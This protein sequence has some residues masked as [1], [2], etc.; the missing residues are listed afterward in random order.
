[1]SS[2]EYRPMWAPPNAADCSQRF[3][4]IYC[5]QWCYIVYPPPPPIDL[6]DSSSTFSPLVIAVIGILASAFLLVS[7][8]T[9]VSKWCR[10]RDRSTGRSQRDP[11]ESFDETHHPSL[12]EPWHPLNSGLD[13]S[14][15]R[16]IAVCKYKKGDG[17]IE[18]TDCS[19]C[20]SEFQEGE[21]LRL[22]PKCSHAFH[23]SC[24]DI[25]L[26]AHSNCPLC[27]ASVAYNA[28]PIS[29]PLPPAEIAVAVPEESV[30]E[31]TN[32]PEN[33]PCVEIPAVEDGGSS[34]TD[35]GN[36][37]I[38]GRSDQDGE[39]LMSTVPQIL[40]RALSDLGGEDVLIEIDEEEAQALRRSFSMDS[41]SM[42]CMSAAV[43]LLRQVEKDD[44]PGSTAGGVECPESVRGDQSRLRVLR[45]ENFYS[46]RAPLN[47]KRSLSRRKFLFNRCSRSGNAILPL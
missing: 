44:E 13:E 3:C 21:S 12:S 33:E 5:P 10:N 16:S 14:A 23:I 37:D 36:S 11:N 17:L 28:V 45:R 30:A 41:S 25:W 27:R 22:L 42:N 6:D 34:T 15:I 35:A 4:S 38:M 43:P 2:P 20:L 8:Y 24:I 47:M 31:P 7:Y 18:G 9:V 19:V 40:L 26:Q 1:M 32:S 29:V 39:R 46:V